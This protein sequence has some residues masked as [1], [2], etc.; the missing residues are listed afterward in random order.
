MSIC[1]LSH[2]TPYATSAGI[3]KM[4]MWSKIRYRRPVLPTTGR[5]SVVGRFKNSLGLFKPW[6][7]FTMIGV[8]AFGR[9]PEHYKGPA[10][11]IWSFCTESD[12]KYEHVKLQH[13]F[14]VHTI[15][16]ELLRLRSLVLHHGY[17]CKQ[18]CNSSR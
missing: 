4:K 7:S 17:L 18:K 10:V 6:A 2:P 8:L 13:R 16:Y 14:I 11:A 9:L 3:L 5:T 12:H 1:L 15:V